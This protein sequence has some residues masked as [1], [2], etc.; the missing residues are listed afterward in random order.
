LGAG[1]G[2]I[3]GTA[4]AESLKARKQDDSDVFLQTASM[5]NAAL[6]QVVSENAALRAAFDSKS[7]SQLEGGSQHAAVSPP[8]NSKHMGLYRE[9]ADTEWTRGGPSPH[10]SYGS[11]EVEAVDESEDCGYDSLYN[12]SHEGPCHES[13]ECNEPLTGERNVELDYSRE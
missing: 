10:R 1:L 12:K 3:L 6:Q 4:A 2:S 8:P 7:V 11:C 13:C 9:P 5:Q